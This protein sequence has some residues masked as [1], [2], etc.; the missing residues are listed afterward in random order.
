MDTKA[1][2]LA[3]VD[4]RLEI[5]GS[6]EVKIGLWSEDVGDAFLSNVDNHFLDYRISKLKM[7]QFI[8]S[9]T[10]SHQISFFNPLWPFF[11]DSATIIDEGV[12]NSDDCRK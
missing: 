6:P 12:A 8:I 2:K 3:C 9:Q 1:L 5:S 11:L 4:S 10:S 7:S